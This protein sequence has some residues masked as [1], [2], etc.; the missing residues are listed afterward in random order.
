MC[1]GV[2]IKTH[3]N[4]LQSLPRIL[5]LSLIAGALFKVLRREKQQD[6]ICTNHVTLLF[7][8]CSSCSGWH[9]QSIYG[10]DHVAGGTYRVFTVQFM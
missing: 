4:F 3:N 9:R 10:A 7:V 8:L 1:L 5:S 2:E 6:S